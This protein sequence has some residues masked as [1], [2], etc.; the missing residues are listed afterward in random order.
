MTHPKKI[1]RAACL[2]AA[3]A[4]TLPFAA[5]AQTQAGPIRTYVAALDGPPAIAAA[6]LGADLDGAVD[7]ID[8]DGVLLMSYA[9]LDLPEALREF[10]LSAAPEVD[11]EILDP[12]IPVNVSLA[13]VASETGTELRLM[14]SAPSLADPAALE[15]ALGQSLPE[16]ASI[17][18]TEGATGGCSGQVILSQDGIPAKA[19]PLYLDLMEKQGFAITDASDPATSFFIGQRQ[20][21]GLFLY[22][23]PDPITDG[24][25]TVIVNYLEE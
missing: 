17:L 7:V 25:S 1:L 8:A 3:M 20:D 10:I 2:G 22:L 11:A 9:G 6:R 15:L 21:C 18:M 24:R 19:A 4:A 23:E 13:F 5:A 12:G 16:G 14:I